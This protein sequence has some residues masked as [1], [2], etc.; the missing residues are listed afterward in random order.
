MPPGTIILLNGASSSGKTSILV[1]LQHLF[2]ES[3][4]NAGLDKFLW[5]LPS[6][7]LD[8]PL[9][10][11]ILGLADHAGAAGHILIAGMHQAISALARC[12]NNIVADHVLV[13]KAWLRDCAVQFA[14]LPVYLIGIRCPLEILEQRECSRKDRTLGQARLQHEIVHHHAIYDLEVDTS[15]LTPHECAERIITCVHSAPPQ[16]FHRLKDSL[17]EI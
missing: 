14:D 13:E 17:D 5:M 4:L 6:R 16:A 11:D 3:Y 10:D 12:G 15:L 1:E 7:Y 2:A 8:R 9:W